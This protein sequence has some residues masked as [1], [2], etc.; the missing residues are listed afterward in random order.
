MV[1]MPSSQ[2]FDCPS[3]PAVTWL[4]SGCLVTG[5]HLWLNAAPHNHM[6][7]IWDLPVGVSFFQP[8][9]VLQPLWSH[10]KLATWVLPC[11]F[12]CLPFTFVHSHAS[13]LT[14][15]HGYEVLHLPCTLPHTLPHLAAATYC[16][17]A[18]KPPGTC[19]I[20]PAK[21]MVARSTMSPMR[22]S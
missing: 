20:P 2:A 3:S 12:P 19:Q 22:F 6:I 4:Q 18:R 16:L 11:T 5:W 17:P 7:S 14:Q 1:V 8:H 9:I 10:T 21:S 13:T 15:S